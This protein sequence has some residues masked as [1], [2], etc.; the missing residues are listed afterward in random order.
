MSTTIPPQRW[1]VD[2]FQTFAY[3]GHVAHS[4]SGAP[5]RDKMR[6]RPGSPMRGRQQALIALSI[7]D[8]EYPTR[9]RDGGT[10]PGHDDW[11]CV[12]DII[13][14]G[15]LENRGTGLHPE[16]RLTPRG[17]P[18]WS[19]LCVNYRAI[20][21]WA[22][23]TWEWLTEAEQPPAP[24]NARAILG[25]GTFHA[26]RDC[27]VSARMDGKARPTEGGAVGDAMREGWDDEDRRQARAASDGPIDE[28]G[29]TAAQASEYGAQLRRA[30]YKRP[31]EAGRRWDVAREGWDA[32][33]ARIALAEDRDVGATCAPATKRDRVTHNLR[34][35]A[36]GCDAHD[37]DDLLSVLGANAAGRRIGDEDCEGNL[38]DEDD[39]APDAA[40]EAG[41][42]P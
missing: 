35:L 1:G 16:W 22:A 36:A 3:A 24:P 39:G 33:D 8:K 11:S 10:L 14:A 38:A 32:E 31:T 17:L 6:C 41:G 37:F 19:R 15:L 42:L 29:V 9:L 27:G 18:L 28:S 13:A 20:G 30:R 4:E 5:D 40:G 2:H 34:A 12:D 23:V 26:Y 25:D 7:G 21:G